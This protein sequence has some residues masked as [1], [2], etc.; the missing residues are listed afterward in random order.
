VVDWRNRLITPGFIDTH[1]HYPQT[2]I[3]ASRPLACCPGWRHTPFRPN[4]ASRIAATRR[5]R[6]FFLNELLR[7]G[8][9]SALVYCTVHPQSVDAFFAA[10]H[11]RNMRMVAAR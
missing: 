8:T 5:S 4:A 10:S 7:C 9:T 6:R 1:V 11:A 3:I 2:D